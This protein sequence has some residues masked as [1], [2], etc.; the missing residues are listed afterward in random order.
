MDNQ[1][2]QNNQ[3]EN[4]S[5]SNLTGDNNQNSSNQKLF[6][7][8]GIAVLVILIIIGGSFHIFSSRKY[9]PKNVA[10]NQVNQNPDTRKVNNQ[11]NIQKTN[12][13]KSNQEVKNRNQVEQTNEQTNNLSATA[14]WKTY[15]NNNLGFE[16][17][18]P[19]TFVVVAC[20]KEI[21]FYYY[22]DPKKDQE[23]YRLFVKFDF[24]NDKNEAKRYYNDIAD[25]SKPPVHEYSL[26]WH[27]NND[28]L[29]LVD[30][31]KK[32]IDFPDLRV[33]QI[34]STADNSSILIIPDQQPKSYYKKFPLGT[35]LNYDL[36]IFEDRDT[37]FYLSHCQDSLMWFNLKKQSG[38]LQIQQ[39]Y[40][41]KYKNLPLK[42][43]STFK[44]ISSK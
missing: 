31:L 20:G 41:N 12:N 29:S 33:I 22:P 18:Y 19:S 37:R 32:T 4:N 3:I 10:Q 44:I 26:S 8:S 39:K 23:E 42:I 9:S 38:V 6:W 15:R 25:C 7:I 35:G 1:N 43:L 36:G 30:Y 28:N 40:K 24:L 2:N 27:K 34:G 14:N 17:K 13:Q 21:N 5:T 16:F 11:K